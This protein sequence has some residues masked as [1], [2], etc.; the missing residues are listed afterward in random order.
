MTCDEFVS[1]QSDKLANS[2]TIVAMLKCDDDDD[3]C[4]CDEDGA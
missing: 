2:I 4:D 1:R 3:C